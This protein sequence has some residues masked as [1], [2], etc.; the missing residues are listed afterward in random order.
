MDQRIGFT[1]GVGI[2]SVDVLRMF[3]YAAELDGSGSVLS[4]AKRALRLVLKDIDR[5]RDGAWVISL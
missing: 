2:L 3:V 5:T 4:A 1:V